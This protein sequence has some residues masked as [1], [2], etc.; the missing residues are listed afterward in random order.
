[1]S[2]ASQVRSCQ[3]Q[4]KVRSGLANPSQGQDRSGQ[5][6]VKTRSSQI[7]SGLV[8]SRSGQAQDMSVE[9]Q[10]NIKLRSVQGRVMSRQE[11]VF[12]RSDQVRACQG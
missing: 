7:W 9:C 11:K 1:M 8:R 6:N 2:K 10:D 4:V 3:Y 5:L 12:S